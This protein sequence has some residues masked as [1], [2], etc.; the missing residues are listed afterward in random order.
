MPK[1]ARPAARRA[2]A[3]FLLLLASAARPAP[4]Q[5]TVDLPAVAAR[6]AALLKEHAG[7]VFDPAPPPVRAA[8]VDQLTAVL[9]QEQETQQKALLAPDQARELSQKMAE[10]MSRGI[11]GKYALDEKAVLVLPESLDRTAR[12]AGLDAAGKADL[13]LQVLVHELVHASQ[14]RHHGVFRRLGTIRNAEDLLVFG[15]VTE[16]HAELVSRRVAAKAGLSER[17]QALAVRSSAGMPVNDAQQSVAAGVQEA[18]HLQYVK[19]REFFERLHEKGGDAAV[20]S[21]LGDRWPA[22]TGVILHPERFFA[23]PGPAPGGV[24]WDAALAGVDALLAGWE[25]SKSPLGEGILRTGMSMYG[26]PKE[27]VDAVLAGFVDGRMWTCKAG[28]KDLALLAGRFKDTA[29]REAY[30]A[31]D[32]EGTRRLVERKVV[33]GFRE[34][35]LDLGGGRTGKATWM[36]MTLLGQTLALYNVEY[37]S[38]ALVVGVQTMNEREAGETARK[39]LERV[40]GRLGADGAR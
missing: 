6:A 39:V 26:F 13:L 19:G 16:G 38:G 15:A 35:P 21:A 5:E 20:A 37:A 4:A 28:G 8:T 1:T 25:V 31:L 36:T 14:D 32:R 29:A 30:E 12:E 7:I 11:L 23:A 10:R 9:R 24:E 22:D 3:L 17:V 40:A 33:T 2:A 27:K 34:S 18:F